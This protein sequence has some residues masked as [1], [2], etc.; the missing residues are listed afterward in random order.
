[1]AVLSDVVP[2]TMATGQVVL[3]EDEVSLFHALVSRE[4]L[5]DPGKVTHVLMPHHQR[6][7]AQRQ[8]VLADIGP[9]DARDLDL[10]QRRVGWNRREI[11]FT[12]LGG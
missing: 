1:M 3:Q 12:Q 6:A 4:G 5:S 2:L 11:K 10:H 9:T 8:A 7:T